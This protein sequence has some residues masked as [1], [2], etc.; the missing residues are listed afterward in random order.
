M[1]VDH[2]KYFKDLTTF[3][4]GG[5]I[6]NLYYPETTEDVVALSS[7]FPNLHILGMGSKIL[8]NEGPFKHVLSTLQLNKIH[9]GKNIIRVGAGV[10]APS[11]TYEAS[12]RGL[13]GTEF[14]INIPAS[15]GGAVIM[16]AGFMGYDMSQICVSV[17]YV[18]YEGEIIETSDIQWDRRWCSLQGKG[19][20]TTVTLGLTDGDINEIMKDMVTY[21][22]IRVSSQPQDT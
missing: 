6:E 11:I 18:N 2:N 13:H 21:Q 5:L 1:N 8:A 12:K 20:V 22:K 14:L 15:I 17:E 16:N 10:Y 19:I 7:N 9:I 3:K 4:I